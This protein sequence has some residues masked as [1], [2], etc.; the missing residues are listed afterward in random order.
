M[1]QRGPVQIATWVFV[2]YDEE[3]LYLMS[4]CSF[5][6]LTFLFVIVWF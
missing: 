1:E 5:F 4:V 2:Q 6:F 3:N